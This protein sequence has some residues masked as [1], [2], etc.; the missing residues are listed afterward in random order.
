MSL[1]SVEGA[2]GAGGT[3]AQLEDGETYKIKK[4]PITN[5]QV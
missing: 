1:K 4:I 2:R 3:S 5:I